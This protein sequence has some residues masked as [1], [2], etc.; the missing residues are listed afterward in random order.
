MEEFAMW[1]KGLN[2]EEYKNHKDWSNRRWAWEFLRRNHAFQ[3]RCRDA[4]TEEEQ[5]EVADD[6]GLK[7]FK[8]YRERTLSRARGWRIPIFKAGAI[9][10][11]SNVAGNEG[12]RKR[13]NVTLAHGQALIRFDLA[14]AL[15]SPRGLRVQ[16]AAAE[17]RLNARIAQ[18]VEATGKKAAKVATPHRDLFIRHLRLLDLLHSKHTEEQALAIV[19]KARLN[20]GSVNAD[21]KSE[22]RKTIEQAKHYAER[23]YI[24]I[25]MMKDAPKPKPSAEDANDAPDTPGEQAA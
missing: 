9:S 16:L 25:A 18:Y 12:A 15:T 19:N 13:H 24:D 14:A 23:G 1:P 8:D 4:R 11:W 6:F 2:E 22:L 21:V 20:G 7:R 3:E 10:S 17:K 5:Q